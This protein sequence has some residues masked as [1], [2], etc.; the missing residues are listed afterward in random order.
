MSFRVSAVVLGI[1]IVCGGGA[2]GCGTRPAARED[3]KTEC[4]V[5]LPQVKDNIQDYVEY[6][7]RTAAVFSVD[8]KARVTGKLKKVSF[9]EGS[10][11][12][13]GQELFLIDPEPYIAQLEQ[14]QA[15]VGLY[16]AQV[17][18]TTATYEQANELAKKNPKTFSAL[19]LRTYKAQMDE[20]AA[21]LKAAEASRKIYEINKNYTSVVA[22]IDGVVGR[23]N[24]TPGNV[25]IQDQTL[26]TTVV[27]LEKMYVYF[28]MDAPTF[29]KFQTTSPAKAAPAPNAAG[30]QSP[31]GAVSLELPGQQA[32]SADARPEVMQGDIDFFNNQFN[33]ATDTILVRGVFKNPT[34][35]SG[36][37]RLRPGMFVRL[38]LGIGSTY[39]A[40]LVPDRALLSKMGKKY[41]YVTGPDNRVKEVPVVIGQLQEDGLRVIK[42]GEL[43]AKDQVIVS[44]LLD[45]QPK[46]EVVPVILKPGQDEK[47]EPRTK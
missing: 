16:E 21:G 47:E 24:Q 7:G 26:L 40:L 38:K 3:R 22:E 31:L 28:D 39:R 9:K 34:L 8:V 17:K 14:A 25:I 42:P 35:A 15:Q 13:K 23:I 10:L 20:A 41:L 6:T 19:Q 29:A 11:V 33:P 45:I 36:A 43:T 18:L 5:L 4:N 2:I 44:R 27:S 37:R 1:G 32:A 30:T 12:Q 46:Q